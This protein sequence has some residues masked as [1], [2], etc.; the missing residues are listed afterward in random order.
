VVGD[1]GALPCGG[2]GER[3]V[4]PRVIVRT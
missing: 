4:H 2:D 3:Y 1:G